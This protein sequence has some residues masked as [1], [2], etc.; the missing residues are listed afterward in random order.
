L[1]GIAPLALSRWRLGPLTALSF[2]GEGVSDYLD[3]LC[4]SCDPE[5][6]CDAIYN[7]ISQIRGWRVVDL[8]QLRAGALAKAYPPKEQY[9][10]FYQ[11][12]DLEQCPFLVFPDGKGDE[13]WEPL[14]KSYGKKMRA[15]VGYYE[16]KLKAVYEVDSGYIVDPAVLDEA[17]SALFELHR[18]RWNKR[19]LPGVLGNSDVQ[20]FH[21]EVARDFLKRGWLRLHYIML[22]GEYQAVLYCFAYR[23]RTCYYQGGFEPTLAKL[24]LGSTLTANAIRNSIAEERDEFDFLRGNEPYKERWTQGAYRLNCRRLIAKRRFPWLWFAVRC[25]RI[26]AS[27]EMKAKDIMHH[28]YS[29]DGKKNTRNADRGQADR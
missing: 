21:R 15:H 18:R 4:D 10:L 29:K 2:M 23:D 20:R 16:R 22:D 11:D 25:H 1:I 7:K 17:M 9:K 24:S 19:W 12:F 3:F 28:A 5:K 26:A 6:I 8:S 14:L 13:R 27:I